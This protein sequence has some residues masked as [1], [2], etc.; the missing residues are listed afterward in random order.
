MLVLSL[1]WQLQLAVLVLHQLTQKRPK[2]LSARYE[3]RS[4]PIQKIEQ[5]IYH[6]SRTLA[7]VQAWQ[8]TLICIQWTIHNLKKRR[9][10]DPL[11]SLMM[12][13]KS[14]KPLRSLLPPTFWLILMLLQAPRAASPTP[15]LMRPPSCAKT[16][17]LLIEMGRRSSGIVAKALICLLSPIAP[18]V[19]SGL[20]Q[21]VVTESFGT[22]QDA[23]DSL[24]HRG[25]KW[26]L[27]SPK[28]HWELRLK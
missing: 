13:K 16:P 17:L 1:I 26:I 14:P 8:S 3:I 5:L 28:K 11:I 15:S 27:S 20:V 6:L 24:F 7:Q 10:S 9:S 25:P 19:R 4:S 2:V 23:R 21:G 18:A 12:T 22:S